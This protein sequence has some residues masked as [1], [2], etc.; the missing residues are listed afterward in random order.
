MGHELNEPLTA[1]LAPLIGLP[2][3]SLGVDV[4]EIE[5]IRQITERRPAFVRRVFTAEERRYA[6]SAAD[7]A[8]RFAARFAA[9]EATMKALGVG[10]G[11]VD[12]ADMA[13]TK[14]PSGAPSLVVSGRAAKHATQLGIERF[15]I[16]LSHSDTVA[17]AVVAGLGRA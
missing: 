8:E 1:S 14:A 17:M 5:R 13:V 10:L 12:F 16:T 9:K 11:G 3:V 2:V 4:V 7:S 6:Q 15:V